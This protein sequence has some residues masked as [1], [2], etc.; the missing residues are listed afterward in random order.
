MNRSTL[1]VGVLA[2]ML[3]LLLGTGCIPRMVRP[4]LRSDPRIEQRYDPATDSTSISTQ[5]FQVAL[6]TSFAEGEVLYEADVRLRAAC[7][8]DALCTPPVVDLTLTTL[9]DEPD[10]GPAPGRPLVLEAD[11]VLIET[12]LVSRQISRSHAGHEL[13]LQYALAFAELEALVRSRHVVGRIGD[14]V[15]EMEGGRETLA[16]FLRTFR[17]IER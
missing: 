5:P 13:M 6:L 9:M 8:G 7:P 16:A 1:A 14:L 2:L 3:A 11:G 15:V 4:L 17:D 12:R 10:D